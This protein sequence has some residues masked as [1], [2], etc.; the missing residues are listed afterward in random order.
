MG[1]TQAEALGQYLLQRNIKFD[2]AFVGPL[3]RQKHTHEIVL[4]CYS[5]EDQVFPGAQIMD[6][7]VEHQ[8]P[9]ALRKALPNLRKTVPKLEEWHRQMESDP[10]L[11]RKN[12][13]LSFEYF[14]SEWVEGK[15]HVP[16]TEPW[17]EFRSKVRRGLSNILAAINKGENI[18]IFTSGGTISAIVGEVLKLE[19][20]R[21]IAELNFNVLN[22]S[23]TT[24][25]YRRDKISLLSFNEVPHLDEELRT[26]V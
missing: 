15:V 16:D 7:L 6:E 22:A 1:T 8:G 3:R 26:F 13:L 2:Q 11:K 21:E 23:F 5:K 25:L 4:D 14:I 10:S 24:F 19:R 9:Q 17:M 20:Q 18:A 12:S